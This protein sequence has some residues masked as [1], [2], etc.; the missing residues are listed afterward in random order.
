MEQL[1][2][3]SRAEPE[4]TAESPR[5]SLFEP[6][7]AGPAFPGH[8]VAV[9]ESHCEPKLLCTV[10][11]PSLPVPASWYLVVAFPAPVVPGPGKDS[12]RYRLAD[13]LYEQSVLPYN[14][15]Q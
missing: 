4:R 11:G 14:G 6:D 3:T 1:C 9:S 15:P 13:R 5:H 7:I 8:L 10:P 12:D 2:G